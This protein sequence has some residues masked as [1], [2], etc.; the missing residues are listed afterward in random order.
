MG[1]RNGSGTVLPLK[2]LEAR[3]L[4]LVRHTGFG[5]GHHERRIVSW[6]RWAEDEGVA[7]CLNEEAARLRLEA[8]AWALGPG[9]T[10]PWSRRPLRRRY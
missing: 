9:A 6:W 7:P 1:G 2:E 5:T 4:V 8:T 10:L 3:L